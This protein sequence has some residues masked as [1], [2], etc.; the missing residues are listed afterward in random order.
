[1]LG[2]AETTGEV[3]AVVASIAE[4]NEASIRVLERVG[5]FVIIGTCR[6]SDGVAEVVFR[7][8]LG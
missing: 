7:R 4:H 8:E 2:W 1:L 3:T 6:T 5:G